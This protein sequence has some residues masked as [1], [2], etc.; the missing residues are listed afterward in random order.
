MLK[1]VLLVCC[2][3]LLTQVGVGAADLIVDDFRD[4]SDW[5]GDFAVDGGKLTVKGEAT[6]QVLQ[7]WSGYLYLEIARTED[8][9]LEIRI[10]DGDGEVW[11]AQGSEKTIAIPFSEFELIGSTSAGDKILSTGKVQT[12]TLKGNTQ[13][14]FIGLSGSKGFAGPNVY[15]Q[16][17]N[18]YYAGKTWEKAA[19]EIKNKG[20]T[21]VHL[22]PVE[23]TPSTYYKQKEMVD[24]FHKAGLP[25][26]LT[27][28]PGTD[29]WAYNAYPQWH[30]SFLKGGGSKWSWRVYNCL[31][32]E[33]FIDYTIKY[34]QEQFLEYGYDALHISEPW[35]EVWGGPNNPELYACFCDRCRSAFENETGVDPVELFNN[36]SQ[37]YYT[38]NPELYQKWVDFRVDTVASF[39]D[40]IIKGLREVKPDVPVY[41][42][43]LSDVTVEP[44][45]TREYQAM[46]LERFAE[47][48]DGVI[49]ET[50]WQDWT[51]SDLWPG[52]ILSY[53]MEYSP[54]VFAANPDALIFAQ[55]DVGSN[56][57]EMHRSPQWLLDFS[58][59]AYRTGFDG[60]IVY[61]YSQMGYRML[62]S[63]E[64]ILDDFEKTESGNYWTSLKSG[65]DEVLVGRASNNAFEGEGSLL[66]YYSGVISGLSGAEKDVML[67][68]SG[69]EYF[70]LQINFST[71]S[72]GETVSLQ[73]EIVTDRNTY[74][75][76]ESVAVQEGWQNVRLPFTKLGEDLNL[77]HVRKIRISLVKTEQLDDF[78][79]IYID[80]LKVGG[81]RSSFIESYNLPRTSSPKPASKL[82]IGDMKIEPLGSTRL[83]SG[84]NQVDVKVT[85]VS[86]E[87]SIGSVVFDLVV[88]D[89]TSKQEQP[90]L[91]RTYR[92]GALRRETEREVMTQL[93]LPDG[94]FEIFV[95]A[96][97][98]GLDFVSEKSDLAI[99]E[100]INLK[101]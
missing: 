40:K 15:I 93:I 50:A 1:Y 42:M 13:L 66:I 73:Y 63:T 64:I 90:K 77:S 57:D 48:G 26:A 12:L 35:L 34:L 11:T 43:F 9:P 76:Q 41:V 82:E 95:R 88:R 60:Y 55:P 6:K 17:A 97:T 75:A 16:T 45:K 21:A 80:L 100:S 18:K 24:A 31:R 7:D 36:R 70:D 30:Q 81:S 62:P 98:Q 61:E 4:V 86:G 79:M 85:L 83:E 44:G 19:E 52:Y 89:A 96:Y 72:S 94:E 58:A 59:Y 33:E 25:V 22:T 87:R 53:G 37:Y 28:Y 65:F 2:F 27:I 8:S 10:V 14:N 68:L 78:G 67:D 56:W 29:F 51:R 3:F 69:F 32:E 46:D 101:F 39:V 54:R 5:L 99:S 84:L 38:K 47:I 91:S 74:S 71:L 49:I 92:V 20:Y 23:L